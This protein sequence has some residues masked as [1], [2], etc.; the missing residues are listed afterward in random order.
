MRTLFRVRA[1]CEQSAKVFSLEETKFLKRKTTL[2]NK[3]INFC[4]MRCKCLTRT[5]QDNLSL[6]N[7]KEIDFFY[8][9]FI[10]NTP[11]PNHLSQTILNRL[12][13]RVQVGEGAVVIEFHEIY[14]S[15][16]GA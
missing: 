9:F 7:K 10:S 2:P 12:L 8:L 13:G 16:R 1:T 6:A 15:E 11:H 5:G 3:T 4:F 14:N